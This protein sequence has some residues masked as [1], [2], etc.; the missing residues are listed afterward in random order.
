[1]SSRFITG[2]EAFENWQDKLFSSKPPIFFRMAES[3]PLAEIEIGPSLM[4]LIGGGPGDGKTAFV[5]QGIV[6]A[7]RINPMLRAVICNVEMTRDALLDRQL[8]RLSG[9]PL[10]I[11]R[12]RL[13]SDEHAQRIDIG[14]QILNEISGRLAFVCSPYR[15][16]D[17][18]G[19]TKSFLPLQYGSGVIICLDYLQRISVPEANGDRRGA[20][21]TTVQCMRGWANRGAAVIA[22]SAI[23]R[24]KDAAGRSTYSA[25]STG[26][27]SF[28]E[29]AELEYGADTAYILGRVDNNPNRRLLKHVKQR[30]GAI[31]SIELTFNGAVQAFDVASSEGQAPSRS[32]A[33][34]VELGNKTE[35]TAGGFNDV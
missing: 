21:D 28:K 29:S 26:I 15:L 16:E 31:A 1:M 7:M 5:M 3:G 24:Q 33:E 25:Q 10:D 27:G 23:A 13:I 32:P 30:N 35:P 17:I 6:D 11:I 18:E 34:L 4:T 9:V 12:K 14:L 22:V 20:I 19:A 2:S 8:A